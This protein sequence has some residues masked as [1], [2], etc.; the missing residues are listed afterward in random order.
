[1]RISNCLFISNCLLRPSYVPEVLQT[2]DWE[3]FERYAAYFASK[4][5]NNRIKHLKEVFYHDHTQ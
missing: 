3:K 4:A 5:L 1:M 2:L